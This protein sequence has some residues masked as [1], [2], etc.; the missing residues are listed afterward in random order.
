MKYFSMIFVLLLFSCDP[1]PPPPPPPPPT[2]DVWGSFESCDCPVG[3]E[4]VDLLGVCSPP[5]VDRAIDW[6]MGYGVT[7]FS[8]AMRDMDFIK[9]FTY[10]VQRNGGA[11]LRAGAQTSHDWC[12]I[13]L[14]ETS[15][16]D[17][18]LSLQAAG[19][20]PCGPPHASSE[21]DHN[22]KVLLEVTSRIHNIWIQL[23][24]TFTYK[25]HN[26][27]NDAEWRRDQEGCQAKNI[28]Y[29]NKMFDHIN[30]IVKA[31]DYK[32]VVYELFNE[33]VHPLSAHIKDEDVLEMFIHARENTSLPLGTDFH[34]EFRNENPWPGRYPF[35]WRDVSTYFA[36]HPR[37]NPEPTLQTMKEAN[38]RWN[39]SKPVWADETV[40]F[41]TQEN[42]DKYNLKGKG[43]IALMGRG[44]EEDR[45]EVTIKHLKDIKETGWKPF[46]HSVCL[47]TTDSLCKMAPGL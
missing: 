21:A 20:L 15:S 18:L 22:L 40:C 28:E 3:T 31:G 23:I 45:W 12:N 5:R 37:R 2:C 30:E 29:F 38:D 1:K 25:S 43:T 7:S 36:L 17:L 47:I 4:K 8:L 14:L 33:V 35:V 44:T 16:D 27:C 24:P 10:H 6:N 46:L 13:Q 42:V 32:H 26:E 19:Y 34:G 11:V 9:E 39:Y 41:A